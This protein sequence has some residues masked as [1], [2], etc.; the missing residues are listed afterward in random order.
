MMDLSPRLSS[1]NNNFEHYDDIQLHLLDAHQEP[2]NINY[3]MA[4]IQ[5]ATQVA[6]KSLIYSNTNYSCNI[7]NHCIDMLIF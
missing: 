4:H 5:Q 1:P 6:H 2:E 7:Q 3:F